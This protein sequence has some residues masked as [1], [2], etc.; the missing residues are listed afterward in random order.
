[1]EPVVYSIEKKRGSCIFVLL[2]K[3]SACGNIVYVY[4]DELVDKYMIYTYVDN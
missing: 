3:C 1:M 2:S 4:Y